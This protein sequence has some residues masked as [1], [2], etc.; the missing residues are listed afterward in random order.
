MISTGTLTQVFGVLLL[1]GGPLGAAEL[2]ESQVRFV[3]VTEGVRVLAQ[4]SAQWVDAHIDLPLDTGDLVHV[5]PD[6]R[7][8]VSLSKSALLILDGETD[9][10]MGH[11]TTKEA[12]ITLSQGALLG[13]FESDP[14]SGDRWE[15]S[16]PYGVCVVRGTEFALVHTPDA[17]THLGVFK[18]EVQM[19]R[20]E[21]AEGSYPS[22]VIHAHE[23]GVLEKHQPL[24]KRAG[25]TALIKRHFPQANAIKKR[26]NEVSDV[27]VPMTTDYRLV[28]RRKYIADVTPHKTQPTR[29]QTPPRRS[30][31]ASF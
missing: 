22:V 17:G 20:A 9:I 31:N 18:G 27:W 28:L 4:G 10:V 23:E 26:F 5:D 11:A 13:K 25:Y 15:F 29:R 16:T 3:N 14:T 1:V 21:S 12:H 7:A 8:E 30:S 24:K 6:N 2:A 19:Q